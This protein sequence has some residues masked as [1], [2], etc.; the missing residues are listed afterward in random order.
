MNIKKTLAAVGGIAAAI[1]VAAVAVMKSKE[2]EKYSPDWY[3]SLSDDEWETERE[4]V[5]TQHAEDY[6]SAIE[7]ENRLRQFDEE[8]SKRDWG[9]KTPEAPSIHREHG[10]YLSNDD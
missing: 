3:K 9:D 8:K 1:G 10:W 4:A 6:D 2:P 7:R 5:R